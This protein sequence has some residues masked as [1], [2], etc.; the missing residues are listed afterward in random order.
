MPQE[1][2]AGYVRQTWCSVGP[3]A[4]QRNVFRFATHR[5]ERHTGNDARE[6]PATKRMGCTANRADGVTF[7]RCT[8][9]GAGHRATPNSEIIRSH[10]AYVAREAE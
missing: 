5:A 7:Q 1:M 10:V 2:K 8:A 6:N 3:H 4:K 9:T